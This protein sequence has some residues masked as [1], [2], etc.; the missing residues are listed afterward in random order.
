MRETS[1]KE[2]L[3]HGQAVALAI[4]GA[5]MRPLL[6]ADDTTVVVEPIRRPLRRGDLPLYMRHDGKYVIHRVVDVGNGDYL[7]L[8]DNSYMLE[9]VAK[10]QMLG[11][12]TQFCRGGKCLS[13]ADRSYKT[14][15]WL[16]MRLTP[17]R[18]VTHKLWVKIKETT[19]YNKLKKENL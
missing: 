2:I 16:W 7:T 8:G 4:N 13:V 11:V 14:Y 3:R 19:M 17:L 12:V 18:I 5:S 15:V 10:R 9:R 1:Y 6:R